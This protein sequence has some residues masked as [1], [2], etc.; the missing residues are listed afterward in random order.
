MWFEISMENLFSI[1]FTEYSERYSL[2]NVLMCP[3]ASSAET[4]QSVD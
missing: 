3:P 2:L 1:F 4:K